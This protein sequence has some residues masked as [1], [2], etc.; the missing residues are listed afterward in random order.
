MTVK[1]DSVFWLYSQAS[2]FISLL[3]TLAWEPVNRGEPLGLGNCCSSTRRE[4]E[5]PNSRSLSDLWS[6]SRAP[7]LVARGLC[8]SFQLL[9][10]AARTLSAKLSVGSLRTSMTSYQFF[11]PSRGLCLDYILWKNRNRLSGQLS[12]DAWGTFCSLALALSLAS[13]LPP[14]RPLPLKADRNQG[15]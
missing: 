6:A 5:S 8:G 7:A 4:V 9:K 11:Y 14:E 12:I 13:P 1:R 10:E 2:H 3:C 15:R